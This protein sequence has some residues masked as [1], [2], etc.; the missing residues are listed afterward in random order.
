MEYRLSR[1]GSV[2]KTSP[3][4]VGHGPWLEM[5]DVSSLIPGASS[6]AWSFWMKFFFSKN[7]FLLVLQSN[8]KCHRG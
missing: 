3:K 2:V 7:E 1:P 5:P 6:V 8:Y 4:L